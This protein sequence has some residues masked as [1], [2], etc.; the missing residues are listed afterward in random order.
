MLVSVDQI[1]D[2]EERYH[3]YK[4]LAPPKH[5]AAPVEAAAESISSKFAADEKKIETGKKLV[6]R[7]EMLETAAS[8]PVDF[9]FER[10]I[11]H[12]DSVYSNFCELIAAAK[13]KIGRIV[14][15]DSNKSTGYATGFL[16]SERLM[17]TN[18]HV[19]QTATDARDSEVQFN[20]ELDMQGRGSQPVIFKL[21]IKDFFYSSKE[22][23]YCLVA[24]EANDITGVMPLSNFGYLYLDPA[25]GK[26][27][28]E[29]KE[30]LNI[31]HHPDGDYKQLSI[32]ENRFTKMLD[33]T[34]WYETDTAPGSSGSPVFNDQWQVVAL[35]H[36]GV[37]S[38]TADGKNYL[39]RNGKIIE[40]ID[41]KV[42]ISK[43]CWIANE[44]I[45][46]SVLV[47]D[48]IKNN[49]GSSFV[50]G[51]QTPLKPKE[52]S[53]RFHSPNDTKASS[54][55]DSKKHENMDS[56]TGNVKILFP[57]SLLENNGNLSIVISNNKDKPGLQPVAA[58][59]AKSSADEEFLLEIA[60]LD[61]ENAVDYS[62]CKGYLDTFLGIH[63]PI[64][65]PQKDLMKFVA[66]KKA[67]TAYILKYHHFSVIYHAVRKSPI[68]SAINVDGSSQNRRD[69]EARVDLWLRDNRLD[70]DVQLNDKYYALSGF[71][72]G[73]MSRRE[74][75]DWG[76]TAQLAKKYADM[77]CVYTNAC[78]QVPALNRSNRSGIWGKLEMFILEKGVEIENGKSSKISVF[79]G[80][81][82]SATDPVFKD[83]QVP[84]EFWK[85]IL[86]FNAAGNLQ[87]TA[88]K[89]SQ[90]GLVGDIN[91]EELDL[92][93]N[94]EF[95]QYQISI[96]SLQTLTNIDFTKL[97]Q[98]DTFKSVTPAESVKI[99]SEE[100]FKQFVNETF[101]A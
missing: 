82:F 16:V 95:E 59:A 35:H 49:A 56:N 85:L 23:D 2:S 25:L 9:A 62:L 79:N 89:L 77:T 26:L 94:P 52:T 54:E 93:G 88:F 41:G 22:L 29:G 83:I 13:Q 15:K 80:P 87:A 47:A 27:G 5:K 24:V 72:R 63:I 3:S 96:A 45:R 18:W 4:K 11:G 91:F 61:T 53:L 81:I 28:E 44:G 60:R 71:D 68:I 34:I 19:F 97:L 30:L 73:H 39:D 70:Y 6:Q 76:E 69:N 99:K 74:D 12:N 42:D 98:Y 20:Y 31:I 33:E 55:N 101:L 36:M 48:I 43:I 37:A 40:S 38:K 100:E 51:M 75:A 58:S 46:T 17:L 1:I 7:K 57:A 8:E 65:K 84:M 10:A 66:R 92:D 32:R 90:S 78:P 21:S 86:W 50:K 64:P 67:S 14:I